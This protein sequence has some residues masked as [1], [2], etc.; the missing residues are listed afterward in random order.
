MGTKSRRQTNRPAQRRPG[1]SNQVRII[2]GEHR[3]RRLSFADGPG[4]R[5]TADRVRETLFNWLLP[6]LSGAHCLD[7]FAGS[8]ALGLEAASRGAGQV[9][10]LDKSIQVVEQLRRH[11][12]LL[13][14][15]QVRIE[16]ADAL[17]WLEQAPATPYQVVFLDPPFAD[18]LLTRCCKKLD[19]GGWLAADARIYLEWDLH[20]PA[21]SLPTHWQLLR[22]KTAGQVAYALYTRPLPDV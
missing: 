22:E 4:L 19:G 12:Q 7:L 18:D 6:V 2:G 10:L 13:Q 21:P 3:G 8:G 1:Q 15:E 20:G 11:Q 16:Q 14:L 9:V 5:P 17:L